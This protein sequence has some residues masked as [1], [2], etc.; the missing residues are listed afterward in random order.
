MGAILEIF[1]VASVATVSGAFAIPIGI[2]LGLKPLVVYATATTTA[3]GVTWFL[4][5][6]GHRV[7]SVAA[8]RF[9]HGE[10]SVQRINDFVARY[11]TIG[12][13]LVG[14]SSQA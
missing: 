10:R 14:P 1:L 3:I 7:R 6:A 12:F 8:D 2:A 11:G 13:G 5:L 4:L 9:G